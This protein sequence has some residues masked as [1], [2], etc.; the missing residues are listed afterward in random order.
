MYQFILNHALVLTTTRIE[1]LSFANN[2]KHVINK[3]FNIL[4][5]YVESTVINSPCFFVIVA[6]MHMLITSPG[7]DNKL[8]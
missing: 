8:S 3:T 7:P 5:R 2:I 4:I 6:V 1:I